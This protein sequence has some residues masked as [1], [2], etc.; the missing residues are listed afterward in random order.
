[1]ANTHP[2]NHKGRA[3]AFYVCSYLS[4]KNMPWFMC[5]RVDIRSVHVL[6]KHFVLWQ[7]MS[8]AQYSEAY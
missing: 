5:C 4:F 8:A 1:M 2:K 6:V 7:L 3:A